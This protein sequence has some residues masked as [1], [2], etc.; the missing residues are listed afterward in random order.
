MTA[1]AVQAA[2][3]IEAPKNVDDA[4]DMVIETYYAMRAADEAERIAQADLLDHARKYASY[5]HGRYNLDKAEE[6][7]IALGD[8]AIEQ[9]RRLLDLEA[10]QQAMKQVWRVVPSRLV[11]R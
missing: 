11:A 4:A 1:Q 3:N 8:A 7:L 10:R 2:H 5:L 9:H 6:L